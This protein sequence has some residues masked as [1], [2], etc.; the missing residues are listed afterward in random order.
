MIG[1]RAVNISQHSP[2][3]EYKIDL[4]LLCVIDELLNIKN[5]NTK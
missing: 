1:C 2:R 4:V 3:V 5:K